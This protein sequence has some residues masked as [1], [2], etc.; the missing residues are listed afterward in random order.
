MRSKK[1]SYHNCNYY[2]DNHCDC[3]MQGRQPPPPLSCAHVQEL[4]ILPYFSFLLIILEGICCASK[5]S[6]VMRILAWKTK[7]RIFRILH[8]ITLQ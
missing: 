8:F 5:T 6:Q 1:D 4:Y 3:D 2:G 7:R